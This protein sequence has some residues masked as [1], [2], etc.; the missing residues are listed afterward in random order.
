MEIKWVALFDDSHIVIFN[1]INNEFHNH[2]A[3]QLVSGIQYNL[4]VNDKT[5]SNTSGSYLINSESKHKIVSDNPIMV[6]LVN[7]LSNFGMNLR[8]NYGKQDVARISCTDYLSFLN[9]MTENIVT[10]EAVKALYFK[11]KKKFNCNI[12]ETLDPRV[13]KAIQIADDNSSLSVHEIVT[14][15]Y[16]SQSAF[17][18]IMKRETGYSLKKFLVW[19][20]LSKT[21]LEIYENKQR[22]IDILEENGYSDFPHFSNEL[23]KN[24]G[25]NLLLLR[26]SSFLQQIFILNN[27]SLSQDI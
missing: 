24:F 23:R 4:F 17:F 19:K 18:S 26:K 22:T 3:F 20:R 13:R 7:P 21:L 27:L 25:I 8:S 6:L 9:V 14:R 12:I 2:F 10:E 11:V 1:G 15:L 5:Y 16:I